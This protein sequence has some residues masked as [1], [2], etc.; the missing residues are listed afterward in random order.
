MSFSI[1]SNRK[2]RASSRDIG[3]NNNNNNN[4]TEDQADSLGIFM[5]VDME[6]D[7]FKEQCCK[8]SLAEVMANIKSVCEQLKNDEW[9]YRP[10]KDI[11]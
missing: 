9:K 5:R 7:N 3:N 2:R 10:I 4:N 6:V 11:V 8:E 1:E